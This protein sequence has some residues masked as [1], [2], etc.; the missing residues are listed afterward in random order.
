MSK[1]LLERSI[2]E[3]RLDTFIQEGEALLATSIRSDEQLAEAE[4][5]HSIWADRAW[6]FLGKAFDTPGF[7]T[8]FGR[9]VKGHIRGWS[10]ESN[11][12]YYRG[13]VRGHLTEL[14]SAR[15]Q[16]DDIEP[17][18]PPELVL[19]FEHLHPDIVARAKAT[20]QDGQY[21]SAVATAFK[22]VEDAIRTKTKGTSA[23]YGDALITKVFNPPAS[24]R[25]RLSE[26][27]NEQKAAYFLFAGANGW[28][29]N[30][31]AHRFATNDPTTAFEA[32][33]LASLLMKLVDSAG[34]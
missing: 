11:S 13:D 16:L 26:R 7:Q 1:L 24:P 15:A 27:E 17:A 3:V 25:L 9:A 20:F 18:G 6:R 32:I 23:D 10:F 19:R 22:T 12:Q 28:V 4:S 30:A 14:K 29:R 31:D 5:E 34:L 33:A 8:S 2:V 21:S